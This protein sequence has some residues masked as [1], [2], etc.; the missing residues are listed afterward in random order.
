[1]R[2]LLDEDLAPTIAEIARGQGLDVVSVHEVGRRQ[3]TDEEQLRYAAEQG[4]VFITRNRDDF[5]RLT[6]DWFQA[7]VPHAGVLI[8][9]WSLPNRKPA[10]VARS[11]HRWLERRPRDSTSM[12]YVVD[13]L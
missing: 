11:L 7:G 1:M 3:R 6:V 4:R 13:F 12:E 8:V 10:R 9:P 5:I 2:F